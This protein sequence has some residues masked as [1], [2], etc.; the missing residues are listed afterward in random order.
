MPKTTNQQP[1]MQMLVFSNPNFGEIRTKTIDDEPWLIGK[2]VAIAL[3]YTNHN[4]ALADHVDPEDK[5]VTKRYTPGGV[6]TLTVINESGLYSLILSSKLPSA[7]KFKHWV[8]S[9]VLPSIR[10][11]GKY[12]TTAATARMID[13][14]VGNL[15]SRTGQEQ[16]PIVLEFLKLNG[17]N[18]PSQTTENTAKSQ[19]MLTQANS[20]KQFANEIMPNLTWQFYPFKLLFAIYTRWSEQYNIIPKPL[21]KNKFIEAIA[22]QAIQNQI[23]GWTCP[24]RTRA[25]RPGSMMTGHEPILAKYG[26]NPLKFTGK[27]TYNGLLRT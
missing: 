19:D 15:L 20:V 18:V 5:G 6:Q 14:E 8:T 2:D 16:M 12:Q 9:E 23:P 7:K 10:K 22:T 11:T 21:T 26:L 1:N 27:S 4:K 17:Y 13:A 3:G 25:I 24:G